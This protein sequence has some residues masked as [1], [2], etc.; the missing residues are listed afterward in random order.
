M[1]PPPTH[2]METHYYLKYYHLY[3]A[4]YIVHVYQMYVMYVIFVF[5]FS[6]K[7]Y[8]SHHMEKDA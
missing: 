1:T 7:K 2:P 4:S 5:L 3:I 6:I 8:T